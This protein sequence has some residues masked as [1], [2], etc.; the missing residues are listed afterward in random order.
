MD[1]A[2]ASYAPDP[3]KHDYHNPRVIDHL[4]V[5]VS[6]EP[7]TAQA[8]IV[9]QAHNYYCSSQQ[10]RKDFQ[11][12][13]QRSADITRRLQVIHYHKHGEECAGHEHQTVEPDEVRS[14]AVGG[15][16]HVG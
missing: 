15:P 1:P 8:G 16:D 3:P 6:A 13:A 9:K 14:Q 10:A 4:V 7:P 5:P 12:S 11:E 2:D